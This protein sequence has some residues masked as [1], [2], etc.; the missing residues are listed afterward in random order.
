M[1]LLK[2]HNSYWNEN[3]SNQVGVGINMLEIDIIYLR[4]GLWLSHSW[5]PFTWMTYGKPL[6]YFQYGYSNKIYIQ[7]EFKTTNKKAFPIL[8]ELIRKYSCS[9]IIFLIDGYN[10][11]HGK[12]EDAAWEFYLRYH[13]FNIRWYKSFK[14]YHNIKPLDLY[15]SKPWYKKLNHF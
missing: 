1:I 4:G 12:R 3:I 7:I 14:E 15:E 2:S 9:N 11:W 5:R 6:K 10:R 13:T 8:A